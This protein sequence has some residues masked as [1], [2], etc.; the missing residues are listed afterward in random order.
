MIDIDSR[1]AVVHDLAGVVVLEPSGKPMLKAYPG[2]AAQWNAVLARHA[3][4]GQVCV[5]LSRIH[6]RRSSA[7]NRMLWAIYTQ[8]LAGLR[9]LAA[10]VGERC[11]FKTTEELHGAF[12]YLFLGTSVV[13]V[14]GSEMELPATTTKL[15]VE[16][17]SS[18]VEQVIKWAGERKIYIELEAA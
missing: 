18:Y 1:G 3:G 8:V 2:T 9:E 16:Q 13:K 4:K 6:E 14:A 15:T 12:K 17:F 7:Q 5:T 10:E 11:P